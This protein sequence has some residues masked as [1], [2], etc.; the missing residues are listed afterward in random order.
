MGWE[1]TVLVG[2]VPVISESPRGVPHRQDMVFPLK[3]QNVEKSIPLI[4]ILVFPRPEAF[5]SRQD[6]HCF[7]E[8]ISR[9]YFITVSALQQRLKSAETK[10]VHT[11]GTCSVAGKA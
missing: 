6:V 11:K 3:E 9:C 1:L 10:N 2:W 4:I 8:E 7:F 5:S